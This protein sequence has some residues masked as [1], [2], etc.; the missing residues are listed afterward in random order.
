MSAGQ[1]MGNNTDYQVSL[2]TS[3]PQ[4]DGVARLFLPSLAVDH[5]SCVMVVR[6]IMM[7]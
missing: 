7:H 5:V 6:R 1:R 2:Y 4:E 3:I